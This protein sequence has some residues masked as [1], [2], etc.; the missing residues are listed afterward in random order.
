MGNQIEMI[1][2]L[3][4]FIDTFFATSSDGVL[5]IDAETT[6]PVRFNTQAHRQLGYAKEEFSTLPIWHYQAPQQVEITKLALQQLFAQKHHQFK[7][8]HQSKTGEIIEVSVHAQLFQK[9][10]KNFIFAIYH[11]HSEQILLNEKYFNTFEKANIGIAQVSLKGEFLE[12]NQRW[13]DTIGYSADELKK[14]RF[15]EITYPDDLERDEGFVRQILL[16]EIQ[17]FSMEKRYFHKNGNI[18]WAKLTVSLNKNTEGVPDFFIAIIDDITEKKEYQLQLAFQA[19][20][21]KVENDKRK[22]IEEELK[23]AQT[24]AHLGNWSLDLETGKVYWSE[25][26]YKMYGFDPAF[27]PPLLNN[28]NTLFTPKSWDLLSSSIGHAIETGV[29]YEVELELVAKDGQ[30]GWMWA[31]GEAV[32]DLNG[33]IV[34]LRGT[35]QD[36]SEHK[37]AEL[38]LYRA[39]EEAEAANRA[40]SNFLSMMSHELRTPMNG[41]LGMA[42]LL[43]ASDITEE[44]KEYAR[45][46]ISS[47]DS[48]IKILSD[49]LDLSKI[50]AGNQEVILKP[51]SIRQVVESVHHLFLGSAANKG[52]ELCYHF[53]PEIADVFIGDSNL[54]KRILINLFHNGIKFT[55]KGSVAIVVSP[56][57]S[58]GDSQILRF[59][60]TDTG[61]GIPAD[62]ID[63]IFDPFQQVDETI[64]RKFGG[65]GLGLTIVKDLVDLLKGT[66][67]VQSTLGQGSCFMV[68][69]PF[70]KTTS[71][72]EERPME[73]ATDYRIAKTAEK[74]ALLVEDDLINQNVIKKMLNR[75]N[76]TCDLA[77]DGFEAISMAHKTKYNLIFMD[78]IMPNINGL[79]A[80][81]EIRKMG[82]KNQET[83]IIALTALASNA[84]RQKCLDA[85]MNDYLSKPINLDLFK[86]VVHNNLM[87]D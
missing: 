10:G 39:K 81:K 6:L 26:L 46:I 19:A 12:V 2:D 79:D 48:L 1:P 20:Q 71:L 15:Q 50:E 82:G 42:Q 30:S 52:V 28:S 13:C 9:M 83:P 77:K 25:E 63:Q 74:L 57:K 16:G 86:K 51:F 33:K 84:D 61:V 66:I 37:K 58:E 45:I 14:L 76:L 68:E 72:L 64:T 67:S 8:Q 3:E 85:G 80:T 87:R 56:N 44:Y 43:E 70:A 11:N 31:L 29:G 35:A 5:L 59:S 24:L 47:G 69:I 22:I 65:T 38:A 27:P 60:I 34:G 18:I 21:L 4:G 53:Q 73:W 40:K 55:Q 23:K 7:T 75:L 41:V 54:L 49:I 62:K 36:I 32:R 78:I 17:N